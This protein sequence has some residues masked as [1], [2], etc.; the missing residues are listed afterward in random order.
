[1][2]EMTNASEDSLDVIVSTGPD[3]CLTPVGST[4]VPVAYCS[5]SFLGQSER[6]S[7]T[8]LDNDTPDF[9]LNSRVCT[10]T[11]HEAGTGAGVVVPGYQGE[12]F[13]QSASPTVFV[14]GW[15]TTRHGD[16]AF[17]NRP[18]A[19]ATEPSMPP[20]GYH[21][22]VE[23]R[24]MLRREED[25]DA[26]Q[27]ELEAY[28]ESRALEPGTNESVETGNGSAMLVTD[29]EAEPEPEE[30]R[31]EDET[32]SEYFER[33][34]EE[35][36]DRQSYRDDPLGHIES[37]GR[38]GEGLMGDPMN[39]LWDQRITEQAWNNPGSIP[40]A[41]VIYEPPP[42]M[43]PNAQYDVAR[44]MAADPPNAWVA[45]DGNVYQA[46]D[47]A[48][49]GSVYDAETW[50][51]YVTTRNRLSQWYRDLLESEGLPTDDR[52]GVNPSGP[53]DGGPRRV[54]R[55]GTTVYRSGVPVLVGP[56]IPR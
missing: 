46:H 43:A 1:M 20:T 9:H 41:A 44:A 36:F 13:V 14:D 35:A 2:A 50:T 52:R 48:Y 56:S 8:V 27:E 47:E 26:M 16:P 21:A 5:V 33:L 4:M 30:Y 6:L 34:N 3:V 42:N 51:E 32:P 11:G 55:T 53:A 7:S 49:Y 10:S 54:Q 45:A 39:P 17:I 15:A 38:M 37:V 22:L 24:V 23:E 12:A 40:G 31:Q 28:L 25:W 18:G 29:A 19:G